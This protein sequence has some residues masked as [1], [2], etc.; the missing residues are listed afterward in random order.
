[1]LRAAVATTVTALAVALVALGGTATAAEQQNGPALAIAF[2]AKPAA[3]DE[4]PI[5]G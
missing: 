3:A 4:E 5:W 2:P 1:M